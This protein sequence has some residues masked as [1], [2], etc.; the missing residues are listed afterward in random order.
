MH[1]FF[2]A[3]YFLKFFSFYLIKDL[4]GHLLI[5]RFSEDR[6]FYLGRQPIHLSANFISL[7]QS[8]MGIPR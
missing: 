4:I 7:S 5:W 6:Q 3:T 8:P 2:K 1:I